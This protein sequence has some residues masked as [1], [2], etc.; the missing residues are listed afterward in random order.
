LYSNLDKALTE[1]GISRYRLSIETGVPQSSLSRWKKGVAVP[2]VDK[3]KKIAT[4]LEMPLDE[5]IS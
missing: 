4:F 1:K 5:L 3:L 2:K